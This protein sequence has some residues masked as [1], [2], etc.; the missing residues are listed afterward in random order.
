VP[1]GEIFA[2]TGLQFMEINTL[3]QLL[4]L[5]ES[6]PELLAAAETLLMTADFL[7]FCLAGTR[8]C[9][10]TI[11]TTSQCVDARRRR[12]AGE[13]LKKFGLPERIFPEIVPPGSKLGALRPSVAQH[14]G[15]GKVAVVAPAAHDT[16]SA[17]AGSPAART[18]RCDWA[19][20][21]S[22]TWSVLGV[23]AQEALI[24]PRV[25]ELDFTNE[26][27]IDSTYRLLRNIV[28][29]WLLQQC[30]RSF[31]GKGR[32]WSYEQLVRAAAEAPAFRSLVSPD[33]SRFLNPADMPAA[34]SDF[35]RETGQPAP[36]TD[37]QFARCIFESLALTYAGAVGGLEELT[38]TKIETLHV[39]GGGSRNSLLNAFTAGATGRPVVAGPTEATV[40]GNVLV[41][42]RSHGE[43]HSLAEIR[44]AVRESSEVT[45][46]A[47]TEPG[48]WKEARGRFGELRKRQA[49]TGGQGD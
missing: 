2:A 27:G 15:L 37:G 31:A 30:R 35:C 34:I 42:A 48:A 4:A 6:S 19:Y 10:F 29:L 43:L 45:E 44:A 16:G 32:E 14:A 38:G 1:R 7:N 46:F 36:E 11:A 8:V 33:D 26:G 39:V 13:L 28:G 5:Q 47:P 20:L 12:W 41:Q 23:E 40:L 17:V 49:G 21:S 18:G 3:Y 9:E 22:G 25:L 24:S